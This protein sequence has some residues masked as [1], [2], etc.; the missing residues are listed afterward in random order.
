M[1]RKLIENVPN[2]PLAHQW[3]EVAFLPYGF[4]KH[5]PKSSILLAH[6]LNLVSRHSEFFILLATSDLGVHEFRISGEQIASPLDQHPIGLR[7][8]IVASRQPGATDIRSRL[9]LRSPAWSS[10]RNFGYPISERYQSFQPENESG[11]RQV[12][13]SV[14]GNALARIK[15]KPGTLFALFVP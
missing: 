13:R 14:N 4:R 3:R 12:F 9:R 5:S 11:P 10:W 6:L 2:F 8:S 1:R 15:C 7:H